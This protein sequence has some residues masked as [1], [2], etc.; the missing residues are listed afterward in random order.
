[1]KALGHDAVAV[2]GTED[3]PESGNVRHRAVMR[4]SG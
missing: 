3:R 4:V 1:M 2:A